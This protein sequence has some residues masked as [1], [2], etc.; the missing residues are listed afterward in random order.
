M[1]TQ[2]PPVENYVLNSSKITHFIL[3]QDHKDNKGRYK[4]FFDFGFKLSKPHILARA[5]LKHHRTAHRFTLQNGRVGDIRLVLDGPI[6][7]P[8]GRGANVRTVW[9]FDDSKTARFITV[10]PLPRLSEK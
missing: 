1:N 7:T 5:I 8:D 3:K 6:E 10:M 2:R 4:F 9:N